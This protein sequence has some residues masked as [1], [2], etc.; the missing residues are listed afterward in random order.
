MLSTGYPQACPLF[1][2]FFFGTFLYLGGFR[3]N[4]VAFYPSPGSTFVVPLCLEVI[5]T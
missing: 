4:L 1:I 2:A 3:Y 5:P